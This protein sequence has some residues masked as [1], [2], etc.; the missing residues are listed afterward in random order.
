MTNTINSIL[1]RGHKISSI[2]SNPP[3]K[4]CV[5]LS[6]RTLDAN[7]PSNAYEIAKSETPTTKTI[8]TS[9][10]NNSLSPL[11]R[12]NSMLFEKTSRK[13]NNAKRGSGK[14]AVERRISPQLKISST[15]LM[16]DNGRRRTW[17]TLERM[18]YIGCRIQ[19]WGKKMSKRGGGLIR[20]L[21]I[22]STQRKRE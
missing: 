16:R 4:T 12:L 10:P 1:L 15:R 8:Q 14:D 19:P 11:P 22:Y 13:K 2:S 17:R 20:K 3:R 9:L 6:M 5:Q 18:A 21:W 7:Q